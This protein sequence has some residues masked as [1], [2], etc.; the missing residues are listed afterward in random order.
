MKLHPTLSGFPLS[1]KKLR[2]PIFEIAQASMTVV[3]VRLADHNPS[4]GIRPIQEI[5]KVLLTASALRFL[6]GGVSARG[7]HGE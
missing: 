1:N 3:I 2:N 4:A 6:L 5:P 7:S